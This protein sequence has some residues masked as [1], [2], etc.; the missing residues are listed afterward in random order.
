MT[1][2]RVTHT[3]PDY[4]VEL[5]NKLEKEQALNKSAFVTLAI[6]DRI[7]KIYPEYLKNVKEQ[8]KV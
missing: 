8:K 3:V 2:I 7:E 1:Y 6:R 4:I 5:L